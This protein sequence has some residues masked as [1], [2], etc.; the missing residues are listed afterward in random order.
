MFYPAVCRIELDR[1]WTE[2]ISSTPT[3]GLESGDRVYFVRRDGKGHG[4]WKHGLV[5]GRASVIPFNCGPRRS[6]HIDIY[7]IETHRYTS[8]DRCN[9]RLYKKT[10]VDHDLM[11]DVVRYANRLKRYTEATGWHDE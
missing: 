8:R 4:K 7:D 6:H 9:I 1:K 10:K 5:L 3:E 11:M 2:R